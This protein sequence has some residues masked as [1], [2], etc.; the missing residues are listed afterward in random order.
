MTRPPCSWTS[1]CW[2]VAEPAAADRG[3]HVGRGEPEL[4]AHGPRGGAATPS[5]SSP[6]CASAY[7]SWGISSS[8]KPRARAWS[9]RSSGVSPYTVPPR[10]LF[11][12]SRSLTDCSVYAT[13]A[14]MTTV[15]RSADAVVVGG[16]T[17]GAWTA[18][19]LQQV[20]GSPTSSCSSATPS[21]RAPARGP[22]A[23]SGR[24][25]APRP[26][27]GSGMF[28]RDFYAR[29][30]RPAG[31]RLRASSRRATSCRA[32]PTPRWRR[33]TRGS[34]CSSRSGSTCA[35]SRRTRSTR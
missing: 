15:P 13:L 31:H 1:T 19:F 2:S 30:A 12:A 6:S 24:R 9:S 29:A 26:P 7:C 20:R 8:A 17:I 4:D 27:C 35:G 11:G 18:W 32:S 21:G 3:R 28:S 33:R 34:R 10:T 22:R 25:A 14:A 5:G 23:W 16:G